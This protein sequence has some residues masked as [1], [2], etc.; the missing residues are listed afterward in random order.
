MLT[1][2]WVAGLA[3]TLL[4]AWYARPWLAGAHA[5]VPIGPGNPLDERLVVYILAW[6]ARALSTNP[7]DVYDM[8]INHPAPLQLTGSEHLLSSQLVF[9]PVYWWTGNPVFATGIATFASY[10]LAAMGMYWLVRLLGS[11]PLV[12]FAAGLALALG[13]GQMPQFHLLQYLTLYF[14]LVAGGITRLRLEPSA[15]RAVPLALAGLL[16]FFSSYYTF[17]LTAFV[18]AVWGVA[19]L[20]RR[21]TGRGRFVVTTAV[22]LLVPALALV[23][24]SLPYLGRPEAA[25]GLTP[26]SSRRYN[27]SIYYLALF[28]WATGGPLLQRW[29]YL[30]ALAVVSRTPAV[31]IVARRGLVL[32]L[33]GG[34]FMMGPGQTIAGID[35]ALPYA[36]L[37]DS[38]LHFVRYP[39]RFLGLVTFGSALLVAGGL[40]GLRRLLPR[41]L[42]TPVVLALVT[43]LATE[44]APMLS[45][46]PLDRIRSL[47]A[48]GYGLVIQ[49]AREHGAA[50][51]I[52]LPIPPAKERKLMTEGDMLIGQTRHWLPLVTGHTGFQ[53]PHRRLVWR[54]LADLPDAAAAQLLVDLTHAGWILLRPAA[55]WPAVLAEQR[56]RLLKAPWLQQTASAD[57]WVLL[58]IKLRPRHDV[59]YDAIA[60]GWRPGLT[61]LGTP[62]APVAVGEARS[63]VTGRL[64]RRARKDFWTGVSVIV[65]ND[66]RVTWP[67]TVPEFGRSVV[68]SSDGE[69]YLQ[70]TWRRAGGKGEP[71]VSRLQLARDV[72]PG[73]WLQQKLLLQTPRKEGDY[74]LEIM[75]RQRNGEG[76]APPV[77]RMLRGS[78]QLR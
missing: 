40:E 33:V 75:V 38:P 8:P 19:E 32:A 70:A 24:F 49:A 64:P 17:V 78:V 66:G 62:V 45:A 20:F 48:A 3:Y 12:A 74:T 35:L 41:W 31:G 56:E 51:L 21:G 26:P 63:T 6:G 57:D 73:E 30:G 54:A 18:A 67:V 2:A 9:A 68:P 55:E 43:W 1:R 52:E 50:P 69:V 42:G 28:F 58:R 27:D 34:L 7:F 37:A 39:F 14:P 16:A 65:R 36:L 47:D 23:A 22:A 60:A 15:R 4:F 61:A 53:P 76:F 72:R 5:A 25:A 59:F 13:A 77:S 11:S 29:S 10:P 71:M 46:P 44:R